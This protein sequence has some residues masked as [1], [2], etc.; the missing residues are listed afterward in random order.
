MNR[1]WAASSHRRDEDSQVLPS[2]AA[3]Y[4][5]EPMSRGHA[6]C[7]KFAVG[8]GRTQQQAGRRGPPQNTLPSAIVK[9]DIRVERQF[10]NR[11]I[12][13]KRVGA[14]LRAEAIRNQILRG[15]QDKT[16]VR[17]SKAFQ[18]RDDDGYLE[19]DA[20]QPESCTMANSAASL[21][22]NPALA[23]AS[24][25]LRRLAEAEESSSESQSSS[26]LDAARRLKKRCQASVGP[27]PKE[28]VSARGEDHNDLLQKRRR[29]SK[30][31]IAFD[32]SGEDGS[33]S[34]SKKRCRRYK[35]ASG[36]GS[37]QVVV[38]YF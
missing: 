20:L 12:A 28:F 18:Q 6:P 3:S 26:G 27:P 36:S 2:D 21:A 32:E 31:S 24:P 30:I 7:Q 11:H 34:P 35:P 23:L 25:A 29:K 37:D 33:G 8:D 17:G 13:D 19:V 9:P 15:S 38:D 5:Q 16:D 1:F 14:S 22:S 4:A 10:A